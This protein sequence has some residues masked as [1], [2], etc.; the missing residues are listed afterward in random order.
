MNGRKR[1]VRAVGILLAVLLLASCP[2]LPLAAAEETTAASAPQESAATEAQQTA[3][4]DSM[5]VNSKIYSLKMNETQGAIEQTPNTPAFWE[6][7]LFR[8]GEDLTAGTMIVRNDSEVSATME[9][10][11]VKLPYGE[12][13]K[14][15]YLDYLMVTIYEGEQVL[16]DNTY[17]HINDEEGG[18]TLKYEDMAPGEEHVYTI[19]MRCLYAYPGDP[20]QDAAVMSWSFTAQRQTTVVDTPQG[21]PEWMIVTLIAAGAA[22]VIIIVIMIVRAVASRRK[23]PAS[24][25]QDDGREPPEE[26]MQKEDAT[27]DDGT[28]ADE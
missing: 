13:A 15:T 2:L 24:L 21:M 28:E 23:R 20:Y 14:L 4:S 5:S 3:V 8:A 27:D 11:P 1:I 10:S 6:Y 7:P 25:R 9:L 18:F 16:Y 22:V 12:E 26:Q 19:K 17:A